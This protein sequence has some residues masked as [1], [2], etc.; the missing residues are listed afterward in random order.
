MSAFDLSTLTNFERQGWDSLTRS[1]GGDFYGALM[2]DDAVMVL[3]NGMVLDRATVASSLNDSPPWD[4]Y[5]LTD[6]RLVQVSDDVAAL[7][8]RATATRAGDPEPF[9]ALMTS[10]YRLQDGE[11]R[12]A[13]YQQTTITH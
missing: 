1:Q 12:L 3:V 2:T 9:V 13:L 8:Y 4:T 7:L 6:E 10:V 5:E 11:P